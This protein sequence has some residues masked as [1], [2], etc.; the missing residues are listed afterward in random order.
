MKQWFLTKVSIVKYI[1]TSKKTKRKKVIEDYLV[2]AMTY[3][4]AEAN[5]TSLVKDLHNEWTIK[6]MNPKP[7]IEIFHNSNGD[8]WYMVK[9]VNEY[10]DDKGRKKKQTYLHLVQGSSIDDALATH[11]EG[12]KGTMFDYYIGGINETNI[13]DLYICKKD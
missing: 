8:K 12:M 4:E 6:S 10:E 9:V 11:K 7:I 5:L 3:T 1:E 2:E 13:Y